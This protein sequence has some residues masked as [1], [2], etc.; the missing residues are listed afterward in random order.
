MIDPIEVIRS[1]YFEITKLLTD[2]G[3]E[4]TSWTPKCRF[5]KSFMNGLYMAQFDFFHNEARI[6][7]WSEHDEL[8]KYKEVKNINDMPYEKLVELI[9]MTDTSVDKYKAHLE[10]LNIAAAIDRL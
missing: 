5:Y 8:L 6:V 10:Q 2:D 9:C 1:D 4:E 3:Y 7:I